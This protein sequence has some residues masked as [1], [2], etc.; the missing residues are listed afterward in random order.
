LNGE[1]YDVD[2]AG[3]GIWKTKMFD[4][5]DGAGND[6][7][8]FLKAVDALKHY[9]QSRSPVL[10]HCHAGKSRSAVLVAVHFMR[11]HGMSLSDAMELISSRRDIRITSG[12]Q[13]ALDFHLA[14]GADQATD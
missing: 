6:P 10:V 11:N 13:E 3:V 5:I 2:Y 8:V 9:R 14:D 4:L 12:M 7:Y 1:S